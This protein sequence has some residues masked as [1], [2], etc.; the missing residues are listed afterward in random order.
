M[1]EEKTKLFILRERIRRK[2]M[3]TGEGETI[4]LHDCE[5]LILL[6]WIKE[7]EGSGKHGDQIGKAADRKGKA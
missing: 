4:C 5:V 1:G 3:K 7:L 6:D 2:M